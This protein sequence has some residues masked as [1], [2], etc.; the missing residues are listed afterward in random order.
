VKESVLVPVPWEHLDEVRDLLKRLELD[1][2]SGEGNE[3][4][5]ETLCRVYNGC[6]KRMQRVLLYLAERPGEWILGVDLAREA[7]GTKNIGPQIKS[8]ATAAKDHQLSPLPVEA[9]RR[10]D[11]LFLFRMP[12]K[13]DAEVLRR[14]V[15]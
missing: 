4:R 1:K 13:E 12:R 6:S 9:K 14:L 5:A 7:A 8:L 15:S 11:R 10:S 3:D 2:D